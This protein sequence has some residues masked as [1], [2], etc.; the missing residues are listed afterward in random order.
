MDTK[1]NMEKRQV[2]NRLPQK[3]VLAAFDVCE[4]PLTMHVVVV[5]RTHTCLFASMVGQNPKEKG[6]LHQIMV[7]LA[8]DGSSGK[9][10]NCV[11]I[12]SAGYFF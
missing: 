11:Y 6:H 10:L 5:Q 4:V 9:L 1:I 7:P 8:V 2:K 3:K 12:F